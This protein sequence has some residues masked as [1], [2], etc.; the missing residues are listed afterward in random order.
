MSNKEPIKV[1][2]IPT[3][4]KF[5]RVKLCNSVVAEFRK[6]E[7]NKTSY[8]LKLRNFDKMKLEDFIIFTRVINMPIDEAVAYR[9]NE[10]HVI[11]NDDGKIS[12]ISIGIRHTI[13]FD[14]DDDIYDLMIKVKSDNNITAYCFQYLNRNKMHIQMDVAINLWLKRFCQYKIDEEGDIIEYSVSSMLNPDK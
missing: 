4:K 9:D 13:D 8:V 5:H 7:D 14:Y 11:F 2:A 12:S 3:T 10:T 6:M 1:E